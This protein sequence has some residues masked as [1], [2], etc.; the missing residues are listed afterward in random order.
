M[1]FNAAMRRAGFFDVSFVV[2]SSLAIVFALVAYAEDP[3]GRAGGARNGRALLWF[4]IPRLVPALILAGMIQVVIPQETVGRYFG[5]QSGLSAIFIAS[6]AGVITPGGPMVSVPLL[7]VLSNSGMA[8][9]PLVAYLTA[10]SL[11]GVQRIIP[12]ETPPTGR[13]LVAVRTASSLVFPIVAGWLVKI[14]FH[15]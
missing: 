1:A 13:R 8:L 11:L 10:W 4:I 14:Y 5:Q 2:L 9:G 15:E 3:S 12:W 6:A 7:V